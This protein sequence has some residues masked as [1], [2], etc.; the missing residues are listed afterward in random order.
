M[1]L[2]RRYSVADRPVYEQVEWARRDAVIMGGDGKAVFEQLGVEFPAKWSQNAVNMVAQKYFRKAGVPSETSVDVDGIIGGSRCSNVPEWLYPRIAHPGSTEGGETSAH[3]V[4]HR[5]VGCWTYWGWREGLINSCDQARIFYDELYMMLALQVA[6]PNSPQWFNTGLHWAY[7]IDGPASGQWTVNDSGEPYETTNSYERPQPHACFIQPVTDD[8]VNPGGMMDLWTREARLFKHG[9]GSGS[10]MSQIRGKGELLSGGGRSSGLMSFLE[11]GDRSAG[12]IQSGGTTRRAALMRC[13]DMDHPEIED[14]IEW[15]VREEAKA[16]ALSLGSRVLNECLTAVAASTHSRTTDDYSV[17]AARA[18]GA[19]EAMIDRARQGIVATAY[20]L[21]WESEAIR[22]V[23]GQNSNN[24]IRVTNEFLRRADADESW[25]LTARTDGRVMKTIKA[26]DLWQCACRAAWASADPGVQYHDTINE[27]HTCS[28]DG[29]I[30]A[31]NPCFP[32]EVKIWTIDGPRR[33]DELAKDGKAVAVLT[34]LSDGKLAYRLMENPRLTQTNAKLLNVIFK[35]NRGPR[36]APS[37]TELRVTPNH[38]FFLSTGERCKASDL[39]TGDSIES[40]Y[41]R[42]A[43]QKGYIRLRATNGD[44]AMEHHIVAE[45]DFGRRPVWP[46]EHGHHINEIKDLNISGNIEVMSASKHNSDHIKGD[47]N[48]MR[49]WYGSLSLK[50]KQ[51]HLEKISKATRG[52][53]N[54]NYG[55]AG[56]LAD[57]VWITD[58]NISK[59]V[60][61]DDVPEGWYLGRARHIRRTDAQIQAQNHTVVSIRSIDTCE[62]VYCGTVPS[63][64]RFFISLGNDHAEGVLVSNCSEYMFLDDTACNLASLR[65]TAFL[66]EEYGSIDFAAYEHAVHLWTMV[67][68]ISV[69][70]ASFPSREIALRSYLYRTLGLGYADLGGLLMRLALPYDS[71]ASRALAAGLTALMTGRAYATSAELADILGP[72]SRWEANAESMS[73]VL[74]NHARA[75]RCDAGWEGL[76]ITPQVL[77][78]EL[79]NDDLRSRISSVWRQVMEARSF[80]NAQVTLLAPTGTIGFAMDCDTMGVEPDFSL[81]KHK[82]LAGGGDM[83]IVNRAVPAALRRLGV[84]NR[85]VD[86]ALEKIKTDGSLEG[87]DLFKDILPVFDCVN[88][89]RPGGRFIDVMGHVKMVAAVQPF[90]SGAV[91]KTINLPNNATVGDFERAF[92]EAHRLGVKAIAPFRDG[93]KLNQP[94]SSAKPKEQ[95]LSKN[96][97][98][99][100][101]DKGFLTSDIGCLLIDKDFPISDEEKAAAQ[102]FFDGSTENI[103]KRS[104]FARGEREYLPWR[105]TLGFEQKVRIGDQSVW[106]RVNEYSDGRPGEFFILLAHAGSTLRSMAELV[107]MMGSLALQYGAPVKVLADRLLYTKFEPAGMIEGHERLRFAHSIGDYVGKELALTYCGR[108]DLAPPVRT[109]PITSVGEVHGD[110]VSDGTVVTKSVSTNRGYTGDACPYCRNTTMLPSGSC[111]RCDTCGET[112]GCS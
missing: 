109:S 86:R 74:R 84:S 79:I 111:L 101:I 38:E 77:D 29:P 83:A 15:K 33:F 7:G 1:Q 100:L 17:D 108:D 88:P 32:G 64:G 19:P 95:P 36:Y 31:S 75:T 23:S 50:D 34:E 10:N 25:D 58:G 37:V 30:N 110:R 21:G 93:C 73:R 59:R 18:A 41:R 63:T 52:E 81:V 24:S 89:V 112:S 13:L 90:L 46:F 66:N 92:R 105:R 45:Y 78:I 104:G 69:Y 35:A 61:P 49:R 94:L 67:L 87:D 76:T 2:T 9:S 82:N 16:A 96:L 60:R 53:N 4:F 65:L 20:D 72:F 28:N 103:V 98:C 54:Q 106:F 5:L 55:N 3:Q 70:M 71:D 26:H 40:A 57:R 22:T 8:L 42:R 44:Y 14:F 102:I 48:P 85:G 51:A 56:H 12:S 27:W 47:L 91:S 43:N 68:E 97:E 99:F 11:V 80:R 6:A 107:S 39:R 62:D